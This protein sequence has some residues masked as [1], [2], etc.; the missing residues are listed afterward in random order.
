MSDGASPGPLLFLSYSANDIEAARSL[1]SRIEEAPIA[2][3]RG[4]TVWFDKDQLRRGEPWQPQLE[5]AIERRATAFAVYVGGQGI[6]NWVEA[7]V[8]L[9]LLR[10][11]AGKGQRF[12]FIPILAPGAKS[13]DGLPGFV[14]QF[15]GVHDVETNPEEF[16]K[17]IAAVLGDNEAGL[18]ELETEPFFGL[19]AI[20]ETRNHLFFGRE[21]ETRELIE[22][23]SET[24]L[25]MVTGDSGSGKSSLV[26]AGVVPQWRGGVLAE[27][28][29][30]RPDEEIWHVIET[31]P[32]LNPHRALGDAVFAA[33]RRLG[34]SAE[35]WG[36]YKDWVMNGDVERVRDGLRCGM[37]AGRARTLIVV[38]QFE[39]LLILT[40]EEQRQ[41][42]VDL[43]L[44]LSD[45]ADDAFAVV[46][47]M[48]R[49]Y[50]NLC[51][52]YLPLHARLEA[53]GRRARYLLGRME[54]DDLRRAI[55]EPLNLAGVNEG[56]RDALALNV[57]QDV[58]ERPGDLALVQ[59]ALTMA[60][61]HRDEYEGDLLRSYSALGRVEG[62]LA[63]AA[64]RVYAN[65]LR[66]GASEGE[67]E[68][69]FLRLVRGGD[70]G[71]ATRRVAGRRE[72][73]DPQW[74]MLQGLADEKGN[75]LVLISG[76]EN[77][78]RIE[79]AHEALV[80]QWKH[81]QGWLQAAGSDKR[82]FDRLIERAAEWHANDRSADQPDNPGH[83]KGQYLAP[84]GR[85][86]EL[87]G[88]DEP[89]GPPDDPG[90]GKEQYLAT[91]AELRSFCDLASR[92]PA[93][94][95]P[96][97]REY[98]DAGDKAHRRERAWE[99]F[100][101]WARDIPSILFALAV[102][103]AALL[104]VFALR[105]TDRAATNEAR[106]FSAYSRAALAEGRPDEAA[107][108][109]LAAWARSDGDQHLRLETLQI[110]SK[111][112]GAGLLRQWT[113]VGVTGAMATKD[114]TRILS[115]SGD[116]ALRVWDVATR[117]QIG[118]DMK[119][120]GRL[121]GAV[122]TDDGK[123]ILSWSGE[124]LRLWDAATGGQIGA[125]MRRDDRV[126]IR[127][128]M[129]TK[130][131]TRIVSWHADGALRLWNATSGNQ[132]VPATKH[133]GEV[134]GAVL[135]NDETRILSWSDDGTLRL[136][137]ASTGDRTG[138]A[139]RHDRVRGVAL[140]KDETRILS[141][142][143]DRTLRLWNSVTSDQIGP[144]MTRDREIVGAALI[145]DG[146]RILSWSDDGTLRLWD[147]DAAG[148][149]IGPAM[150]HEGGVAGAMLM[151]DGTQVLSWSNDGTVRLWN[152][153]WPKGNLLESACAIFG[154]LDT[155][156][157]ESYG[158][159]IRDPV[160]TPATA[161]PAPD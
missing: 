136:W 160:C 69:V 157:A 124:V 146:R 11:I 38:D 5:E 91:G 15:H 55:T 3:K 102:A 139:M 72:F 79:I 26:R 39:E 23:L 36:T 82:I 117:R 148:Q 71:G 85:L 60:W 123:R 144:A 111:A 151:K 107:L 161:M 31:R 57:L 41:P 115:W 66:K 17:L 156:I 34:E 106:A 110:L 74:T 42:F 77:D 96:D 129:L 119:H 52:E 22:R 35:N 121:A 47:T 48:R 92:R 149:Q 145:S 118:S 100:Q 93:W 4:L 94:L 127:G 67:I 101:A 95:S 158:L 73:K 14:R 126:G 10:A 13:L 83:G 114:G 7:E 30:R 33:A 132:I 143:D 6:V 50:H 90:R 97:E 133:K 1:K 78:E 46:L 84:F 28:K 108:L 98:V 86:I 87:T 64:E 104:L 32:G 109:A 105:Q 150:Q 19:K 59:F 62:A 120:D 16:Q 24:P 58:G 122:M 2:R 155:S 29:G 9:G 75:R 43:L 131:G 8:R 159:T 137:D 99:N 113:H 65:L 21:R 154:E 128:A 37:N 53:N 44:A 147:D 25:L 103:A 18:R 130:D 63:K 76:P 134:R 45:P 140:T 20:D 81:F 70:A 142:S 88:N 152:V 153:S 51:S 49:D 135:M 112:I 141:W 56:A 12:P 80:S 116:G 68:A 27:L 40:P 61:Q 54:K 89:A 125:D 138:R